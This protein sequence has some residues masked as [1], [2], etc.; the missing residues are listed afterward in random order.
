MHNTC[1]ITQNLLQF[2]LSIITIK[3]FI[4]MGKFVINHYQN[5]TAAVLS[6]L[7]MQVCSRLIGNGYPTEISICETN[8]FCHKRGQSRRG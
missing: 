1:K 5:K 2:K 3:Y 6:I 4:Q 7:V 8:S